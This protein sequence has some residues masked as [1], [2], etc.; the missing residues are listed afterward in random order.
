MRLSGTLGTR[1]LTPTTLRFGFTLN[2]A[3]AYWV[4]KS[5]NDFWADIV[6]ISILR[7][8]DALSAVYTFRSSPSRRIYCRPIWVTKNILY[9]DELPPRYVCA[10][11]C[12]VT[13]LLSG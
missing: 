12:S 3:S 1:I 8:L 4:H 9:I 5:D 7:F 11:P 6:F 10:E 13:V 2:S